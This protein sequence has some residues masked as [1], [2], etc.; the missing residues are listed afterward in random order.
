MAKVEDLIKKKTEDDGGGK[1][2]VSDLIV[3]KKSIQDGKNTVSES[4]SQDG[5]LPSQTIDVSKYNYVWGES[6]PVTQASPKLTQAPTEQYQS[7]EEDEVKEEV[8]EPTPQGALYTID[9][10][11]VDRQTFKNSMFDRDFVSKLQSGDAT[12]SVDN[13][14]QMQ[15]LAARQIQSGSE[16]GDK[17]EYLKAGGYNLLSGVTGFDNYIANVLE[18]VTGLPTSQNI[19][20]LTSK[21]VSEELQKKVEEEIQKT[22]QYEENF[23][24]SIGEE[25]YLDAVNIGFNSLLESAPITVVAAASGGV[26]PA[27]VSI[28]S[29]LVPAEYA[30]SNVSE[31]D[32]VKN[33][34]NAEKLVRSTAFGVAEGLGEAVTGGIASKNFGLL[35]D[36]MR[37]LVI[38]AAET[39]GVDA[40]QKTAQG[41]ASKTATEILKAYGVDIAKEGGSEMFTQVSQD[42][43]DDL[44]G[45][46][47]L[48]LENYLDNA[49][50]AGA[51]GSFMGGVMGGG[52]LTANTISAIRN[53]NNLEENLKQ[54]V[55]DGELSDEEFVDSQ[56]TIVAVD[57][58]DPDLS[59]EKQAEAA[60]L[61]KE[62]DALQQEVNGL[63]VISPQ[64]K[65]RLDDLNKEIESI[66]EEAV[67]SEQGLPSS[68]QEAPIEYSVGEEISY[69][70]DGEELTATVQ[71]DLG[72]EV[73]LQ[74][75]SG[76]EFVLPKEQVKTKQDETKEQPMLEGVQDGRTEEER[77]Q[78]SA[79]LRTEKTEEVE[80]AQEIDEMREESVAQ[81]TQEERVGDMREVNG[82][83]ATQEEAEEIGGKR[84]IR[85]FAESVTQV[86]D[87]TKDIRNKITKNPL[88]YYEPQV[89]ESMKSEVGNMT[90]E[91]LI[92]NM[93]KVGLSTVKDGAGNNAVMAATELINRRLADGEDI[94]DIVEKFSQ[95]GTRMGQLIAQFA[96][97]NSST[98]FGILSTIQKIADN[99]GKIIDKRQRK[100]IQ[101][102]AQ[103]MLT[104]NNKLKGFMKEKG[105]EA[106][107]SDIARLRELLNKANK[108]TSGF[109]K[110]ASAF[111]P[112]SWSDMLAMTV[113]GNLLTPISQAT[114][115]VANVAQQGLLIP[116]DL[117]STFL[118]TV[119]Q[120]FK[121]GVSAK[122]D[123]RKY[124]AGL[125]GSVVGLRKAYD[126]LKS[127]DNSYAKGEVKRSFRPITSFMQMLSDTKLGDRIGIEQGLMPKTMN[128][129]GKQY[130]EDARIARDK[131]NMEEY[132]RLFDL[133]LSES[134][135]SLSDRAKK[136][137]EAFAAVF[138]EVMFRLL[139]LGDKP[140]Y[141]YTQYKNLYVEG[142]KKGLR[143]EKLRNYV[144]LPDAQTLEKINETADE[145]VFMEDGV[146]SRTA[147]AITGQANR[148]LKNIPMAGSTLSFLFKTIVPYVKTPSNIISQTID[149]A[150][151]PV[152]IAK[153]I[154]NYKNGNNSQGDRYAG[155]AFTGIMMGVVS[156]KLI[157]EGLVSSPFD[158][159][160]DKD[161]E[162]N[163]KRMAGFPPNTINI[164]GV[165]RLIKGEDPK[166]K[167]GD[168]TVDVRKF[169]II[170]AL[171]LIKASQNKELYKAEKSKYENARKDLSI[172]NELTNYIG[173]IPETIKYS[174]EQSFLAGTSAL[175]EAIKDGGYSATRFM[176]QTFGAI[177]TVGLPNTLGA[178]N[179]ATE[180]YLHDMRADDFNGMIN[181][182]LFNR[183]GFAKEWLQPGFFDKFP[184][185]VDVWGNKI[186]RTPEGKNPFFHQFL[187]VSKSQKVP[188]DKKSL[189]IYTLYMR[190]LNPRVVPNMPSRTFTH[191]GQTYRIYKDQAHNFLYNEYAEEIGKAR[192]Y[193]VDKEMSKGSYKNATIEERAE[194]IADALD[195]AN[196]GDRIRKAKDKMLK[197]LE[198][199]KK[200]K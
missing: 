129:K 167:A 77:Q 127:G 135:V 152:A 187:D 24:G 193:A 27:A 10:E 100:K 39:G 114:N 137:Y 12:A 140:F 34:S 181:A 163:A 119:R 81:E 22:R 90:Q 65:Q 3:K 59:E 109:Y 66:G 56:N 84:K 182:T 174:Q 103:K 144:M 49:V 52:G 159:G 120:A 183:A 19:S 148:A 47:D 17:W 98:P 190:T 31:N 96:T 91:E 173:A 126:I 178:I 54:K 6:N 21:V 186:T 161:D 89:W 86:K 128:K 41:L 75:E 70:Q 68:E 29:I 42:L 15:S 57:K 43:T 121:G 154:Y 200:K 61:I 180:T 194:R 94:T 132:D 185:R 131:G 16:L 58:V 136:A 138:P 55:A 112:M 25:N 145:S 146:T 192:A 44:M 95:E 9:G 26:A 113:Q 63:E 156:S 179:R 92:E 141:Y 23:V 40:A 117:A 35:K 124:A 125:V 33:L 14:N 13:D 122:L 30:K 108:S 151:P 97:L 177:S 130:L 115:I 45:V 76:N 51:L 143:G 5:G 196:K 102:L 191:K 79:E 32:N 149:F 107:G 93:S 170:G 166:F 88:N 150:V 162:L 28:S 189:E 4:P 48:T 172:L 168:T 123:P 164:S 134:D 171:I 8:V 118:D 198:K 104:D 184:V 147:I 46:Q 106:S 111:T 72:D 105:G 133:A 80:D 158:F 116:V 83:E 87:A 110:Y 38:K 2:K 160:D 169:G 18:E 74:T 175:L 73:Q 176:N 142:K 60:T 7:I 85:G 78:E 165:A 82:T 71:E 157:A 53:S 62:R 1:K 199:L 195:R 188:H 20:A 50:E 67:D 37:N 139:S 155:I 69:T 64:K 153:S 11:E 197:E 36:G 99:N 101:D